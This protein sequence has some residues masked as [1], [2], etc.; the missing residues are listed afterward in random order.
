M[1]WRGISFPTTEFKQSLRQDHAQHKFP[2][3]D[4]AHIEA[5]GRDPIVFTAHV[6]FYNTIAPGKN[7]SWDADMYPTR[8]RRFLIACADR[9]VGILVHPELGQIKCKVE[10]CDTRWSAGTRGGVDVDVTWIESL[11]YGTDINANFTNDSPTASAEIAALDLDTQV[12]DLTEAKSEIPTET[13]K[14]SFGESLRQIKG[15][16][17][18]A[19]LFNQRVAG[20]VDS[21]AYRVEALS[22]AI[23]GAKT[24]VKNWPV[25][26]SIER[27]K[28]SLVDLKK[29]ILTT[30]KPVALYTVVKES[31]LA[32]IANAVAVYAGRS[33]DVGEI[34]ILNPALAQRPTV[35][36]GIVVRYYA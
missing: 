19:T 23:G 21:M 14:T 11:E 12:F 26:N 9:T 32:A 5:T 17:D 10:T 31:T 34:L 16:A 33:V 6:P 7:E 29:Q 2:D 27:M 8:W 28:S 15:I 24:S 4:G 18:Q 25:L 20:Q 36:P 1:S 22:D 35:Q 3:R 30:G 13:F